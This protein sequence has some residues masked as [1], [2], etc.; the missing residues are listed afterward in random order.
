LGEED[1]CGYRDWLDEAIEN[2]QCALDAY[3]LKT[4]HVHLLLTPKK[5]EE[6]LGLIIL[7]G[8]LADT[9]RSRWNP[10]FRRSAASRISFCRKRAAHFRQGAR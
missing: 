10:R 9:R 2:A 7:Q 5:A 3:V 4:T 1:C 6:V 8:A